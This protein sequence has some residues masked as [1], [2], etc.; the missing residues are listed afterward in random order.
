MKPCPIC[1]NQDGVVY[2]W[3]TSNLFCPNCKLVFADKVPELNVLEQMYSNDYFSGNIAYRDY[4]SDKDGL[5]RNFKHRIKI[6][7][8]YKPEGNLFE[9]GC[10]FGFFLECA[11]LYWK[12]AGSDI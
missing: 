2:W 9:I 6:L 7:R 1:N 5:Q 12:V 4:E 11:S 10:A 8:E 3:A